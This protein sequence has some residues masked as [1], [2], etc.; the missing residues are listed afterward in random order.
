MANCNNKCYGYN[1]DKC[2]HHLQLLTSC[3]KGTDTGCTPW[4]KNNC[5]DSIH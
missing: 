3:V 2:K 5:K 1:N 4:G